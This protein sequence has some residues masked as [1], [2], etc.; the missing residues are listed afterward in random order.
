[1]DKNA[2]AREELA[3]VSRRLKKTFVVEIVLKVQSLKVDDINEQ[4]REMLLKTGKN[5][6]DLFGYFNR[7][8]DALLRYWGD[9]GQVMGAYMRAIEEREQR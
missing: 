1:M 5:F 9:P 3:E 7:G 2:K 8:I 4:M 6:F